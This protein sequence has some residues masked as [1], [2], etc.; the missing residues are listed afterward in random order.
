VLSL[1]RE[2]SDGKTEF[3]GL[4]EGICTGENQGE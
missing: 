1:L 2:I 4:G 3:I